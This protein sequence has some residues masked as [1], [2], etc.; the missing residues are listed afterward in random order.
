MARGVRKE[1]S[2]QRG[3]NTLI[4]TV[5]ET[6]DIKFLKNT[7]NLVFVSRR[8]LTIIITTI[9][10][11]AGKGGPEKRKSSNEARTHSC[12]LLRRPATLS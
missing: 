9:T 3:T 10:M 12:A 2:Q 11:A 6:H 7:C 1:E 4:R 8:D 5:K